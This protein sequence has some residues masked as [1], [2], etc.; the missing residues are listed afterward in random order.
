MLSGL[1]A[2]KDLRAVK[3]KRFLDRYPWSPLRGHEH[4][5]L[6]C[7]DLFGVDYRLFV[8][9][10]GA[11]SSFGKSY[12]VQRNNMT[13]YLDGWATFD[14]IYDNIYETTKLIGTRHYYK[15]FRKTK[16]IWDLIHVYKGVPPY[17]DY[18]K[19]LRFTLDAITAVDIEDVRMEEAMKVTNLRIKD[20]SEARMI[21]AMKEKIY[22]WHSVRYDLYP[23]GQTVTIDALRAGR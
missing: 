13:G 2:A 6:Y 3:L 21:L 17:D 8:A 22:G 15:K 7:A 12:P 10:A 5:I 11:E 18:Y 1:A 20:F 4:E 19:N 16:D 23:C 14:S 9:I